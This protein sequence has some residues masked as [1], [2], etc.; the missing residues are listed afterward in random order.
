LP[1]LNYRINTLKEER[2]VRGLRDSDCNKCWLAID[3][4]ATAGGYHFPCI[5]YMREGGDPVGKV[6][7]NMRQEREERI[8]QHD[9]Q[10]DPIC[11]AMCLDVCIDY[12]NKAAE[13]H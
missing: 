4:M 5:I 12:N 7:P 9:S 3:D 10:K 11:K 1:I 6:G 8:K 13:T 2:H